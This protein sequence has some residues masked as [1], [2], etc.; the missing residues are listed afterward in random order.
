MFGKSP[1]LMPKIG[2]RIM[3]MWHGNH[4]EGGADASDGPLFGRMRSRSGE[5]ISLKSANIQGVVEGLL[6]SSR[7]S[8][9]YRNETEDNLEIRYTFPV[10]WNSAL[11]GLKARIGEKCLEGTVVEKQEA[12]ETYDKAM[13]EGDAAIMV[14]ESSA[15]LY[16]V[17]L[18][19][20][21]PG[22]EVEI[23]I[24]C[25][26]M[27]NFEQNRV[28]LCIP[29]VI[30]ER[31]GD[32]HVAGG[33]SDGE[34]AE[35][36]A[37]ANYPLRLEI[38]IY[39]ELAKGDI[40]SPTHPVEL[41]AGEGRIRVTLDKGATLDRDFV[42]LM[43]GSGIA[44]HASY[45]KDEQGWMTVASY[46][47]HFHEQVEAP[48]CIKTLVDCSGSMH[49]S[50]IQQ[51][52]EGLARIVDQLKEGDYFAFSR[53]GSQVKHV[54]AE[55]IGSGNAARN[56]LKE[57]IRATC[58]DMGGTEMAM[59][60]RA[61]LEQE[62]P[63][64]EGMASALLLITDGDVW[65]LGN[66]KKVARNSGQRIYVIGVGCA[67]AEGPLM[68]LAK[69]TGGSCE[70][71]TPN[72][73]MAE[74]I[75]RTFR[76]MRSQ[77]AN[78]IKMEWGQNPIWSSPT[79]ANIYAGE[80]VHFFALLPAQP[81]NAPVLH[82]Q[83]AGEKFEEQASAIEESA[84]SDLARAGGMQRMR[85]CKSEKEKLA[86][87]L[88]YQLVSPL[89]NLILVDEREE[90]SA[91]PIKTQYVPQMP[92][93]GHGIAVNALSGV[94]A[95]SVPQGL[96]YSFAASRSFPLYDPGS[97]CN[98]SAQRDMASSS[99]GEENIVDQTDDDLAKSKLVEENQ[100]VAKDPA[101]YEQARALREV[102]LKRWRDNGAKLGLE[103]IPCIVTLEALAE[104]IKMIAKA[105]TLKVMDVWRAYLYWLLEKNGEKEA[106]E[107][108]FKSSRLNKVELEMLN[109]IFEKYL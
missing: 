109:G 20:V 106:A 76:R 2:S 54:A 75:V 68:T 27:L 18:G 26:Q 11:L 81:V 72:E 67:P 78:D 99:E 48:L 8:Q 16:T 66:L 83:C 3:N 80:T 52:S 70:F 89:T 103:F 79:P 65:D 64:E 96:F 35:V 100:A 92:A 7:I 77:I 86:L 71:V 33:L 61:V 93:H 87:A 107:S 50:S 91:G 1:W 36:D 57:T 9:L 39:G 102:V 29:T 58:A 42:L 44:S 101:L 46:E 94:K 32:P 25:A 62:A 108:M 13:A 98:F 74:T 4:V 73:N 95:F 31:Y 53:F 23:A 51:A 90:K 37:S 47:P 40:S 45:V 19:N 38:T 60:L 84:D 43:K 17:K 63:T 28:R 12:C 55:K 59:A 49:G 82:W 69:A 6:F 10:A 14:Q 104:A 21:K 105:N 56:S 5:R 41:E 85:S 97:S 34:S 22:E 88:Q 24:H 15:G 30:G